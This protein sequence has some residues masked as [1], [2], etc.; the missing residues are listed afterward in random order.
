MKENKSILLQFLNCL[1]ILPQFTSLNEFREE[2]AQNSNFYFL[3]TYCKYQLINRLN[4]DARSQQLQ[5]VKSF[6]ASKSCTADHL[7]QLG[8]IAFRGERHNPEVAEFAFNACLSI[9]LASPSP[10][11]KLV[12]VVIRRLACL[13]ASTENNGGK[14]DGAYDIYRKAYQIILG[15]QEGEYPI[16]E[17]KWLAMTAWN[18][19]GLAVRLQQPANARKWMKLGLD[20]ARRLNGMEKYL[21]GMEECFAN[22]EKLCNGGD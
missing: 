7:L 14:E 3:Y 6:A 13:A 10:D 19:S 18:K 8:F 15:L 4:E 20:M 17:G 11:Y 2:Q 16:E 9:L 1:Q 22:F 12:S 5:L 21:G